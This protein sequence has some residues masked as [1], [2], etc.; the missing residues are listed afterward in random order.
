MRRAR[1]LLA[2]LLACACISGTAHA[3]QTA[4]LHVQ[5][6]PYRLGQS[7]TVVFKVALTNPAGP[8]PPPLVELD[9]DYPR[10]LGLAVS[11]LGLE[12]CAQAT[13]ET[14]GPEGC[15]ADSQMGQGTALAEIPIGPEIIKETAPVAI[16]RA[17]EQQGHLALLFYIDGASPVN[18][19]ITFA[20]LLL[21]APHSEDI[22]INVPLVP[23]LPDAPDVA[24]TQLTAAFGPRG[25]TYY[26]R[27][28]GKLLAYE[29]QGI[30]LP[31]K[32]PPGGFIF[33]ANFRFLDNTRASTN[34][35]V[36]CPTRH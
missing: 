8:V 16:L 7:T 12:T 19:D 31:H 34:T 9:M 3:S 23:S 30:L 29:P 32:C 2:S 35:T 36:P 21:P 26:E 18:A 1:H 25:L 28:H 13:L 33:T 15:P 10:A 22:H 11:G 27:I 24:V 6:A 17:P 4:S 14:Q 20:G 5:F